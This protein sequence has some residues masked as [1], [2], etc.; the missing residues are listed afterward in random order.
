MSEDKK[1]IKVKADVYWSCHNKINEMSGVYQLNLCNLSDAAV[2]AL[3][4]MG[5]PVQVGEEKKAE[6][7]RYITCKSKNV[8]KVF[9]ADGDEITE[10]IGNGSKGK[11]IISSYDWKYKNKSGTSA[12]LGKLVITDLVEY[13]VGGDLSGNDEDV[14]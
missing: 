6:M 14:L 7:G 2:E 11:A 3:E 4:A 1:R 9:D 12:S 10:N 13:S 8:I 5:I